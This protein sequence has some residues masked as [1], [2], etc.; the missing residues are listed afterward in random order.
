MHE[1]V[2]RSTEGLLRAGNLDSRLQEG[3][4]ARDLRQKDAHVQQTPAGEQVES[5]DWHWGT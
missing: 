4:G 3:Q 5:A 2:C 1:I